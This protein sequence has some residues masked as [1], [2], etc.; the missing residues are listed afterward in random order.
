MQEQR[1]ASSS[2][3]TIE[4]SPPRRPPGASMPDDFRV[5]I[6][7]AAGEDAYPIAGFTWLLVYQEQR[8]RGEGQGAR[9]VPVVGDRT[10]ARRCAAALDYAPL[11][12][13]V[14]ER[15]GRHRK[16]SVGRQSG[17]TSVI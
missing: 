17:D 15:R 4:T 3:P 16:I 2:Q 6:I 8:G 7:D 12:E 1:R 9:Q 10:T 13:A 5:S 11:P 14:V